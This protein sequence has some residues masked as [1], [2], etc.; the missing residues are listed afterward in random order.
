VRA[1]VKLEALEALRGHIEKMIPEL[2]N[3]VEVVQTPPD[4]E[5]TYSSLAIVAP[6]F[7]YYPRQEMEHSHPTKTTLVADVGVWSGTVQLRLGCATP[8]ERFELEDALEQLFLQ[9][10]GAPGVLVLPVSTCPLLG[11]FYSSWVMDEG[12]WNDEMAFSSQHWGVL[13][14]D[15]SLPVLVTRAGVY[16]IDQL[17]LGLDTTRVPPVSVADFDQRLPVVQ[18]NEDGTFTRI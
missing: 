1:V 5:L 3:H 11:E 10:E 7:R 16:D 8:A 9:R 2:R 15:A 4:I 13:E 14:I 17:L 12:D 18:V 6:K